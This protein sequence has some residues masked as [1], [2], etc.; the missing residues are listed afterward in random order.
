MNRPLFARPPPR[1]QAPSF[2]TSTRQKELPPEKKNTKL[3]RRDRGAHHSST[4]ANMLTL[5]ILICILLLQSSHAADAEPTVA[6]LNAWRDHIRRCRYNHVNLDEWKLDVRLENQ[7]LYAFAISR[8]NAASSN[9]QNFRFDRDYML[10]GL[11]IAEIVRNGAPI[12]LKSLEELP[13][14]FSQDLLELYWEC[15]E[16]IKQIKYC[17]GALVFDQLGI[18][19][20]E[21]NWLSTSQ[22]KCEEQLREMVFQAIVGPTD[23]RITSCKDVSACNMLMAME[24]VR[25]TDVLNEFEKDDVPVLSSLTQAHICMLNTRHWC[26]KGSSMDVHSESSALSESTIESLIYL[27]HF[28]AL[29]ALKLYLIR[30]ALTRFMGN[31]PSGSYKGSD[32][33]ILPEEID[34]EIC[35]ISRL[36]QYKEDYLSEFEKCKEKLG[37]LLD[38]QLTLNIETSPKN[39]SPTGGVTPTIFLQL[40]PCDVPPQY[41]KLAAEVHLARIGESASDVTSQF[42][43][44]KGQ[45]ALCHAFYLS[46]SNPLMRNDV[47]YAGQSRATM[48]ESNRGGRRRAAD[49][50]GSSSSNSHDRVSCSFNLRSLGNRLWP[51]GNR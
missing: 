25:L 9:A 17:L 8:A 36:Q 44:A 6:Q 33:R 10:A 31:L 15:Y 14:D 48:T 4:V 30:S 28:N 12:T 3:R 7:F 49:L 2:V 11:V 40:C 42:D 47:V 41:L 51:R 34:Y 43:E 19:M 32:I 24:R 39:K 22:Q 45:S 46:Q 18:P 20:A 1:I 38:T 35:D 23:N 16:T 37:H 5:Y 50:T 29:V 26:T 27:V 13:K 21:F